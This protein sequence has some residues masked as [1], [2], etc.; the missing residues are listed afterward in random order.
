MFSIFHVL[1]CMWLQ[2]YS[3]LVQMVKV[4][5]FE[6]Y[7]FTGTN[8]VNWENWFTKHEKLF[9]FWVCLL[10]SVFLSVT[11]CGFQWL[12]SWV[13]DIFGACIWNY[14]IWSQYLDYKFSNGIYSFFLKKIFILHSIWTTIV[15]MGS[16]W[17]VTICGEVSGHVL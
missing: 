8:G 16:F 7:G 11:T 5:K 6:I 4:L 14:E 15:E 3:L 10:L 9:W 1:W 12:F 17:N 2:W 13:L